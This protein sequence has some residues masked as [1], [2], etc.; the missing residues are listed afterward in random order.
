[1]DY[2]EYSQLDEARKVLET[3]ILK[4]A[5][6]VD[7][8]VELFQLYKSTQDHTN[9]QKIYRQICKIETPLRAYWDDFN[10][11]MTEDE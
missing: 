2:I 10:G 6:R 7:I 11:L 3:A 5:D 9:F 4:Q 8:T 1:L